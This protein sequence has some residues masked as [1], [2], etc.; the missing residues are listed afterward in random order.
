MP[1][2]EAQPSAHSSN[3]T[4]HWLVLAA[5]CVG[6]FAVAYNTTA[7][8]TA[9]PAMKSSLDLSTDALQWVINIYML[10]TAVSLA[11]LGHFA[12]MFGML[13]IF[14]IGLVAFALG[15][16]TIALAGDAAV[17]LGGRVFQGIGV[18]GLIATSVAL[19]NVTTP[20]EKRTG[21]IGI[22]AGSVALGFALGPLIGGVLTDTISWR[23]IFV[24]DLA[25]LGTA[26][27]LC[28]Y[29]A[30][31]GL[32]PSALEAGTRIDYPG[33]AFLAVALGCFLYG[34]TSGQL[35]GWTALQTLA[36]LTVAV[37][38]ACA[39]V[40]RE[41][42]AESPLVNFGF[43]VH[44]DYVAATAGMIINGFS[45]IGVLYFFNLF[46]QAPEGL[47][48]SAAHAGLA[49]LPF[50]FA[51]F[52]VSLL[53][54][55]LLPPERLGHA[56]IGAMLALAIGF[57]LL[58]D[59]NS[60]THYGVLWWKLI[61]VGTGIGLCWSLLPRVGMRVL[62]DASSG[63]GSGVISTCNFIGLA[64][65]TAAGSV[66]ASQ[67]K[68]GEIAPVLA[69]VAPSVPDLDALEATLLH[70]SESQIDS[71]LAKLSPDEAKTIEGL[72]H[73]AFDQAFSGVMTMMAIIGLIGAVL[74][75]VLVRKTA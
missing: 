36:L 4:K 69:G 29:V 11:G 15:S 43:F 67:I 62:P 58:H 13:R 8:M 40:V 38:G 59:T 31:A 51:M 9:L 6:A 27:L 35:F 68:R 22:W 75:I 45:Q 72:L 16:I 49:L 44:A 60:Q 57:W 25:I 74:C 65:G 18:A 14:A 23:A 70:G 21:A 28:L 24:L 19:I 66:V 32:V 34:L 10:T 52:T 2:P 64:T 33:M 41:L 1:P 56:L 48:F 50:T 17:V 7:V 20:E 63:Q 30:R 42:R 46:L 5:A 55:R 26:G 47:N 73:G 61:I 53:A 39:F 71:V 3:E 12:D 37:L 54:P